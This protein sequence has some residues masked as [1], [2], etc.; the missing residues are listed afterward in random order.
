MGIL[1]VL[2]ESKDDRAK[3]LVGWHWP[4]RSSLDDDDVFFR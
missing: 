4:V 1:Q 3:M 2:T